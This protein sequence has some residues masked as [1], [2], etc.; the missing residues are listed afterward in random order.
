MLSEVEGGVENV[1]KRIFS[2]PF[3]EVKSPKPVAEFEEFTEYA[4]YSDRS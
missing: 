3:H 1:Q 4:R 2:L